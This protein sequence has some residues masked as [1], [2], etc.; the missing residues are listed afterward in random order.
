MFYI[1]IIE[2]IKFEYTDEGIKA[3]KE[4]AP[5]SIGDISKARHPGAVAEVEIGITLDGIFR[6]H[7]LLYEGDYLVKQSHDLQ[8]MCS[9]YIEYK[10]DFEK[11]FSPLVNN[12]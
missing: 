12:K 11:D 6:Y 9:Y 10:E 7:D 5:H 8:N 4:F 3:L 1:K 2:A